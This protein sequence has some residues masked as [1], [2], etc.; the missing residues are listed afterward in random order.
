MARPRLPASLRR[1]R[2]INLRVT[3]AEART[4][5]GHAE[6]S[7]LTVPAYLRRRGLRRPAPATAVAELP[8]ELRRELNKIGVNLNQLTRLAHQ[9]R[10]RPRG[11]RAVADRL[12][13]AAAWIET[14]LDP[15]GGE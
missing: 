9:G 14:I 13:R 1:T 6:A 5:A 8:P 7:R 4:L 3:E 12:E 10:Y 11:G 15:G 2:Q